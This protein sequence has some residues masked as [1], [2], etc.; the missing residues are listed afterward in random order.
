[1]YGIPQWIAPATQQFINTPLDDIAASDTKC[2]D[3][4]VYTIIPD[5]IIGMLFYQA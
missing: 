2:L 4:W 5:A 1:M 3:L